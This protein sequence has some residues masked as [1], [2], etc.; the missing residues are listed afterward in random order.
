MNVQ[1]VV[2]VLMT[3]FN[4]ELFIAEAIESVLSS[5]FENFELIIVDDCSQD[6]TLQIARGYEA[7]DKRIRVYSNNHNLG[8]YL[9]RNK[10]A[11]Y[12][13]GKYIK[14]LDAD[15]TIYPHGL[16]VMVRA[17]EKYPNAAF[18]TQCIKREDIKPY[19]ICIKPSLSYKE[20][21]LE[22]GLFL[23]GPTGVII[24]RE[25]FNLEGGFSGKRYIGDIELWLKLASKYSIVKFQPALIWWRIH[26]DQEINKER[27]SFAP[28]LL[29][30]KLDKQIILAHNCP[31]SLIDKDIAY[32]KLNRRFIINTLIQILSKRK[33]IKTIRYFF[34]A[35]LSLKN[36]FSAIFH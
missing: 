3:A 22:G 4:R 2:S 18:G 27:K 20:H 31:L 5:S 15:D 7:K 25:I 24:N 14:Y 29:R 35:K 34:S 12:A 23:A 10:A 6:E 8:D 1:P 11:N 21:Y 16:D 9:N 33:K 26:L 30:Y 17:M 13:K 19:P 28:I 32:K 36:G